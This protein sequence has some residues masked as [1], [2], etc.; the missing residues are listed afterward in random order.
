MDVLDLLFRRI[1]LAARASGALTRPVTLGEVLDDLA[2]YTT[3]KRDGGVDTHDDYL[4]ALM[5][6]VSGERALLFADDLMQDDLKAELD[7][8][9]PDLSV[10]RTYAQTKLRVSTEGIA[11]V[12]AGD[13]NIDLRPPTPLGTAPR[14][15]GAVSP[16]RPLGGNRTA[17]QASSAK[18][19]PTSASTRVKNESAEMEPETAPRGEPRTGP[20]STEHLLESAATAAHSEARSEARSEAHSE[21]PSGDPVVPSCPFCA[22]ALPEGRTVKYC[23]SCGLNLLMKRCPGC[24]AEIDSGWKFCVTCGRKS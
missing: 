21:A 15:Q 13:T 8:P 23:P 12:L 5:R 10:L 3:A 18:L 6:L 16:M 1:V 24:S 19:T 22:H 4:H 2:P 20:R 14:V 9:N 7:S 17:S 11:K